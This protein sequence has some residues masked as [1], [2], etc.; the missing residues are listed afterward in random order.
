MTRRNIN[1]GDHAEEGVK[2]DQEKSSKERMGENN[3]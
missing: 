2:Q 1:A 3:K